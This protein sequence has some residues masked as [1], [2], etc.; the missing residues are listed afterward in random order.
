[1]ATSP[2]DEAAVL[3]EHVLKLSVPTAL[4]ALALL[5]IVSLCVVYTILSLR[6]EKAKA[7]QAA[8]RANQALHE[9]RARISQLG[10]D[11]MAVR[12]SLMHSPESV[13][14]GRRFK[15]RWS[16]VFV[17][18]YPKCGTTWMQ[19]IV[20][21]L[22]SG[23]S[24]EFGEICEVMPWDIVAQDCAQ[25]LD[26]EQP[27]FPRAFKS[28]ESAETIAP[29]GRYIYVLRDPCDALVSFWRFLPGY[30]GLRPSDIKLE[31]FTDAVRGGFAPRVH[32]A[33]GPTRPCAGEPEGLATS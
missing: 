21:A 33:R 5:A 8:Q 26:A 29:G 13:E 24:L 17:T 1:M 15:A 18:T 27:W 4:S 30:M 23:G 20:Q 16:D 10:L 9:A 32:G 28:H 7:E 3:A 2:A 14:N 19:Q 6:R 31:D 25:S 11:L 22:R 12:N